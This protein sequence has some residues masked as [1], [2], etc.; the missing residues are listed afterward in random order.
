[1]DA[2]TI[3]AAAG[4]RTRLESLDLVSNNLA[5]ASTPGYKADRES[6]S[7]Y[8]SPDAASPAWPD[9][10]GEDP[11][12][13]LSRSPLIESNWI[14]MRAG[15]LQ[16][17]GRAEDI[18]VEGGGFLVVDGPEGPLLSRGGNLRVA[19]DG[20]LVT[21][22]GFE[23]QT[24]EPRRIRAQPNAA[25]E[26]QPDGTVTQGGESLGRIRLVELPSGTS[27]TK[28]AGAYFQLES[29]SLQAAKPGTGQFRQG[30]TEESNVNPAES[31]TRLIQILRQFEGLQRALQLGGEMSRKSVEE[32]AR[33]AP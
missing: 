12:S 22:E 23:V 33:V 1:M 21:R 14:D 27:G 17:T 5:N 2:L 6:Y 25:V 8:T 11:G 18:A 19:S 32:V 9:E 28:R 30:Y 3:T 16:R 20:K 10:G 24:V 29:T 13:R 26:V 31:A 4:M 15:Q 7:T